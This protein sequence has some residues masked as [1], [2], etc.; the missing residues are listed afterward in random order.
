MSI[1]KLEKTGNTNTFFQL[2][3]WHRQATQTQ[4]FICQLSCW[5]RQ[6]TETPCFNCQIGKDKQHKHVLQLLIVKLEKATQIVSIVDCQ[7]GKDKQHR[8]IVLIVNF[9]VG[10]YKQHKHIDCV[11]CQLSRR[12][13]RQTTSQNLNEDLKRYRTVS[14]VAKMKH[15]NTSTIWQ[16]N[17]K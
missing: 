6:V 5:K 9:Q 15:T 16:H 12:R 13:G 2:S 14:K 11:N 10:K 7:G 8:H 4:S 17:S 3:S 1:V